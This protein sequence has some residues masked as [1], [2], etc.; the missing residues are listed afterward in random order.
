MNSIYEKKN[1]KKNDSNSKFIVNQL[2]VNYQI[3][4]CKLYDIKF[5]IL[6]TTN[7]KIVK[8]CFFKLFKKIYI[9]IFNANWLKIEI[10]NHQMRK[11]VMKRNRLNER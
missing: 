8:S 4:N 7:N 5:S 9:Q 11:S 3:E 10:K 6:K 1:E 2:I